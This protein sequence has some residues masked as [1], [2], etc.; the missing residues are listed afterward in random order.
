M[1]RATGQPPRRQPR[2]HKKR[3]RRERRA[4]TPL[5]G[6]R[7]PRPCRPDHSARIHVIAR[8]TTVRRPA[9]RVALKHD[10][11][12]DAHAA[13]YRLQYEVAP[14]LLD[15]SRRGSASA[16]VAAS[17]VS[18]VDMTEEPWRVASKMTTYIGPSPRPASWSSASTSRPWSSSPRPASPRACAS[19]SAG[20]RRRLRPSR[21]ARPPSSPRC[22][23]GC[24]TAASASCP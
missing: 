23:G 11:P 3:A 1:V 14:Y 8:P 4:W 2:R 13:T 10:R 21:R 24:R 18:S 22:R 20:T 19:G 7:L 15:P 12:M 6:R 9:G 16:G 5:F 17:T